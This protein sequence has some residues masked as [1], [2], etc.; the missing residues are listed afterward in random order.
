MVGQLRRREQGVR[1]AVPARRARG[2]ADSAGHAGRAAAGRRRRHPGV[3]HRDRGRHPGR[4]GRT[5][6]AVRRRRR[7]GDRLAGQGDPR[8]RVRWAGSD[9]CPGEGRGTRLR[10]GAGLEGRPARQSRVPRVRAELQPAGAM[11][12]RITIAEVEQLV[13]PGE[14]DPD[15]VHLPGIYVQRVVALDAGAGRGQAD[16]D[17]D[18]PS[19]PDAGAESMALTREQ[20]AAR[21]A[22]RA[23]RRLVRQ[24]RHRTADAGAELRPRRRR[25]GPA[26][27]ERHPRRRGLSLRGTRRI[28]I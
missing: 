5:A 24:S 12:G 2:R 1:A 17:A 11:A 7:R 19:R 27:R 22:A 15:D 3:L 25:A 8:D 18:H 13:E 4:R 23:D 14:L 6:L 26:V 20:M 10:A 9:V 21:A 16:R 28:R